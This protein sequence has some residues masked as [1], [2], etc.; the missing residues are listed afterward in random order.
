MENEN[1]WCF[2][3]FEEPSASAG[4]DRAALVK[5]AKW[6][7]GDIITVSFLGGNSDGE[8]FKRQWNFVLATVQTQRK[9]AQQAAREVSHVAPVIHHLMILRGSLLD[10]AKELRDLCQS[11]QTE[12]SQKPQDRGIRGVQV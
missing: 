6:N 11:H 5:G 10:P 3:W 9:A 1:Q 4:K 12:I 2:A 7:S 8:E